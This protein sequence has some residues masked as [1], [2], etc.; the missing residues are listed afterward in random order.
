MMN[1]TL[2]C[3]KTFVEE[4]RAPLFR[5]MSTDYSVV[6][7]LII[8]QQD[9]TQTSL[10]IILQVPSTC[11]G[12]QPHPLSGVHKTVTA[13]SGTGAATSLHRG[14]SLTTLDGGSCTKNMTSTGGC[15]Y[16]FAYS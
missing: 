16:S 13:A 7:I 15:S 11:F 12:C 9:A 4:K 14:Q 3:T 10:F 1:C 6:Y 2:H 8:F 5:I